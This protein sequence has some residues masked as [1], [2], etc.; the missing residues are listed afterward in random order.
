MTRDHRCRVPNQHV[1]IGSHRNASNNPRAQ[2]EKDIMT[3]SIR[4]TAMI[5]I[6]AATSLTML[7]ACG[8]GGSDLELGVQERLH[9]RDRHPQLHQPLLGGA[10][11]RRRSPRARPRA[12][13]STCRPEAARPTPTA[14]TPRS[15]RWPRRTT[16]ASA[17]SRSTPPTSSPPGAGRRK[18]TPDPQPRHPDRRGRV[19][20][21]RRLATPRSSA[22]TT[23]RPARSPGS[24]CSRPRRQG[25][26]R[27]PAGHRRRAERHQPR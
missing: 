21:G 3:T 12:S 16:T 22:R 13:R 11:R 5:G 2:P 20:E 8:R 10:A 14:R 9:D 4:R 19:Q 17:W 1:L 15:R 27:H 24:R 7:A 25:Q 6:V 18:K 26:G 23:C